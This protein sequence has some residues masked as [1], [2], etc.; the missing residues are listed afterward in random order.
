MRTRP[1]IGRKLWF[2]PRRYGWGWSPVC[3]QGWA[4]IVG[5]G[6]AASAPALWVD[7][8]DGKWTTA[9]ALLVAAALIVVASLKGTPPGGPGKWREFR[10]ITAD[11]R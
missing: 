7:R 1:L 8:R 5:A 9:G 11:G 2:G 10:R 3:W 6:L 4:A